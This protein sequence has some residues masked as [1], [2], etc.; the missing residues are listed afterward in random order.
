M[1][2]IIYLFIYYFNPSKAFSV[3]DGSNIGIVSGRLG[4]A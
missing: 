2:L 3:L 4:G 1:E